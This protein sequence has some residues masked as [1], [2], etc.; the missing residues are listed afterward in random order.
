V[1]RT[2][3]EDPAV[4]AFVIVIGALNEL[5]SKRAQR[6]VLQYVVDRLDEIDELKE[7][8]EVGGDGQHGA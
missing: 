4:R 7:T 8:K 5:P 1:I 2:G 3:L 6:R